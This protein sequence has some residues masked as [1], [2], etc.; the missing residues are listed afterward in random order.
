LLESCL[1]K[2][3]YDDVSLLALSCGDFS[4]LKT[5]FL[6]VADRCAREQVALSLPSLR[7]GS[8]DGEIMAR[9]AGIRRTGVTLAPEAGS[10][11]LRDVINKG[12]TEESLL[13]HVRRLAGYGWRHVKLYFMIGL[14]GETREDL[15]AL[16]ELC[17]KVRD[18]CRMRGEDGKWTGPRLAVTASVSPFVP[19]AHTPFQWEAQISLE[20]MK[21]RIHY[22]R[23]AVKR[24]KGLTL[25]W[26]EPAMSHLEGI[27]ARGDRRLA[28]VLE[29]AFRKG[30]VFSSWVEGFRLEPWLEA[31]EE[32]GMTAE[33]WTG[34]RDSESSLPWDHIQAGISRSFLLKERERARRGL[35]TEDCRYAA[36]RH[37]GA[38]D[39]VTGPS[40]LRARDSDPEMKNRL[41]FPERDQTDDLSP[42]VFPEPAEKSAPP[43]L[44]PALVRRAVRYRL[45]H[46]KAGLAAWIS[47]LELQSLLERAMRKAG[48]PL[49]FSRGFH[50]LPLLSFGRAL[51]VGMT[52]LA[53][54]FI[55]TLRAPMRREE[56]LDR[57]EPHMLP[58]LEC[59]SV[60]PLPLEGKVLSSVEEIFRL[61]CPPDET[62]RFRRAWEDFASAGRYEAEKIN[63]EGERGIRDIRPFLV[64]LEF[65][66]DNVFLT[67]NWRDSYFSPLNFVRAVV[68]WLDP[69]RLNLTKLA[70]FF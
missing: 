27:L 55:I 21:N 43:A 28:D 7:V 48:L 69:A 17:A 40:L 9:M 18:C 25:R 13:L 47:Q 31:L 63:K 53:E 38:C 6:S 52:S 46:R 58:G 20:E 24:C 59:V 35:V 62:G 49:A 68:P 33:E 16:M 15:D 57:L 14:P 29:K 54:W 66:G 64:S 22:L 56:V 26:H 12:V 8:V 19:K 39:A 5:L 50:P 42:P 36:C 37:C 23:E 1:Q 45:W 60:D 3:G 2:T 11:R 44:D 34:A 10:Q 30:A 61:E 41:N 32:C 51:P 67:L 70:Q 4:A 65:R